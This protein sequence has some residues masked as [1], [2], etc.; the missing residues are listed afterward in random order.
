MSFT[1]AYAQAAG[2]GSLFELLM[3][4][5]LILAIMYFLVIR[6]QQRRLKEH[7]TMIGALRRG[8]EVVTAGGMIGKITRV[9]EDDNEIE[10]EISQGV[11]VRVIKETI[12]TVM[13]KT[14]PATPT[15][16]NSDTKK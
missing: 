6:P 7:Q 1:P 14:A 2:G 11:K 12:T 8:D 16:A 4:F 15:P 5:V 3:P 13:S 10:I 9:K